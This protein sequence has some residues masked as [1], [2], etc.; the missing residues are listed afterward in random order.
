M[1]GD[2][3][4]SLHEAGKIIR[5][6]RRNIKPV[7]KQAWRRGN[8]HAR[9]MEE[10]VFKTGCFSKLFIKQEIPVFVITQKGMP[11]M[12]EVAPDLV[13]TAGSQLKFQKGNGNF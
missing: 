13:H 6:G 12:S 11:N 3:Q 2:C 4:R 5:Q 1:G 7:R 10:Q 8:D 9:G